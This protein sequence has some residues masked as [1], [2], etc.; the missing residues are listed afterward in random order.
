MSIGLVLSTDWRGKRRELL[1]IQADV[2]RTIVHSQNHRRRS[3]SVH[4]LG[5]QH[6]V[7]KSGRS[8]GGH[9]RVRD[10]DRPASVW[11]VWADGGGERGGRIAIVC[12][13][14]EVQQ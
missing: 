12:T 1:R 4:L 9:R 11:V 10:G 3:A 7:G 2:Y 14:L 13:D 5:G 8:G 6:L